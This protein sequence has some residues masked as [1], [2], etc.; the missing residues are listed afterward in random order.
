M[1]NQKME[2]LLN[3][4]LYA[5]PT[6]RLRSSQLPVGYDAADQ[7][8]EVVIRYQGDLS[9][10][11]DA[12]LDYTALLGSYAILRLPEDSLDAV[13]RLPQVPIWKSRSVCTSRRRKAGP[14]PASIPCRA[15]PPW[16]VQGFP[17]GGFW[18]PASTQV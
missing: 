17:D 11:E 14:P 9:F 4:A 16:I 15:V 6:E 5:S 10:L 2:N 8:F 12:G 1:E 7:T 18:W 3:L 13:S